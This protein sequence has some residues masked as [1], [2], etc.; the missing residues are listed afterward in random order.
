MSFERDE[1]SSMLPFERDRYDLH[2]EYWD[3]GGFLYVDELPEIVLNETISLVSGE[4]ESY[5]T[6]DDRVYKQYSSATFVA[7]YQALIDWGN[8]SMEQS[9]SPIWNLEGTSK[10]VISNE[11]ALTGEFG[12]NGVVAAS[13]PSLHMVL[14]KGFTL[15]FISTTEE[16]S[17]HVENSLAAHMMNAVDLRI[18]GKNRN[19][20]RDIYS[21]FPSNS[22]YS[23]DNET[24]GG[25][26]EF[27]RDP[28]FWATGVDLSCIS[29]SIIRQGTSTHKRVPCATLISP[30]HC[31]T[32]EHLFF[33]PNVGD[34]ICFVDA[35]GNFHSAEVLDAAFA[36]DTADFRILLLSAPLPSNIIPAKVLPDNW[37][38][39]VTDLTDLPILGLD[40]QE[41]GQVFSVNWNPVSTL[42]TIY[43]DYSDLRFSFVDTP[44]DN[45]V[46]KE[47]YGIELRDSG[48]PLFFII[49]DYLVL[50]SV[51]T[52]QT[53]GSF[54]GN[55]TIKNSVQT[56]MN[57]L[58]SDN[59]QTLYD[60]DDIDLSDFPSY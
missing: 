31:I 48:N 16:F 60:L 4:I 15:P 3:G 56:T 50:V 55:L 43:H 1:I 12:A 21:S 19:N 59:S 41:H 30:Q 37:T 11:G 28:N 17:H 27:I 34:S 47:N 22:D 32:C 40:Q 51:W 33:Y 8:I 53:W 36:P 14:K 49:N 29:P 58:S 13:F 18:T 44:D 52:H 38:N 7:G 6:V 42:L 54:L 2:N 24:R 57:Q 20:V 39:F 35:E 5:S 26:N 45:R 9:S 25:V 46:W 23:D 10:A